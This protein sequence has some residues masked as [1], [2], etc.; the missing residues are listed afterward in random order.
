MIQIRQYSPL[1]LPMISDWQIEVGRE[2]VQAHQLSCLG[3]IAFDESDDLAAAWFFV[4][5][6]GS[7]ARMEH[8]VANPYRSKQDAESGIA[9]IADFM[10]IE[11]EKIGKTLN[12]D[13]PFCSI[14]TISIDA[15]ESLRGDAFV[16][17]VEEGV[18]R[19][20][21]V[22]APVTHRFT[23]GLYIREIF[24]PANTLLT[25]RIHLTEHPFVVSAGDISVWTKEGGTM[26]LRA[27]YCGITRP[28]TRRILF[29]HEDTI[30]T[31]FHPTTETD[32]EKIVEQVTTVSA[33]Y[34][35]GGNQ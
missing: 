12:I 13:L 16:D 30:W 5:N 11:A 21:E 18:S 7:V 24:I 32:P 14:P 28:G 19:L 25:S 27:P 15:I 4:S 9:V 1:D 34:L 10:K 6:R 3:V 29:A 23:P 2:P 20:A 31:T 17:K 33:K 22:D 26:R 8:V 35:R